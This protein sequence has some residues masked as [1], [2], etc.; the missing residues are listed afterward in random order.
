MQHQKISHQPCQPALPD[1]SSVGNPYSKSPSYLLFLAP[2]CERKKEPKG[3]ENEPSHIAIWLKDLKRLHVEQWHSF[4]KKGLAT[5]NEEWVQCMRKS[6]EEWVQWA[7]KKWEDVMRY[8]SAMSRGLRKNEGWIMRLIGKH[9]CRLW[10]KRSIAGIVSF[11]ASM[12]WGSWAR[13]WRTTLQSSIL[14]S[15]GAVIVYPRNNRWVTKNLI[16]TLA[17]TCVKSL[18][19]TS[20][21]RVSCAD[22]KPVNPFP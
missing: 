22:N 17:V 6:N 21:L 16:Q 7:W 9:I 15:S 11:R 13:E 5:V 4:M 2:A 8:V 10:D 1:A 14:C 3:L 19:R 18:I 12:L 20:T